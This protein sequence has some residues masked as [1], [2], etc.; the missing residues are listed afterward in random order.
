MSEHPG[1]EFAPPP[2]NGPI[3]AL[4]NFS[5]D[6]PSSVIYNLYEVDDMHVCVKTPI[7]SDN[8]R[9]YLVKINGLFSKII[10]NMSSRIS[11][12][13]LLHR[14]T[15]ASQEGVNHLQFCN[16]TVTTGVTMPNR[17]NACSKWRDQN[18]FMSNMK[19]Y[20]YF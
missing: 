7:F 18:R 2:P 19:S 15:I 5:L 10:V 17:A 14:R 20:L 16:N 6:A 3:A 8:S 1:L 11:L 9:V 13:L 4:P 12:A